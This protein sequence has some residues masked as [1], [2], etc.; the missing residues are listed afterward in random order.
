V[1]FALNAILQRPISLIRLCEFFSD[2]KGISGMCLICNN[3][4]LFVL[5]VAN[6]KMPS[7]RG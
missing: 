7:I 1:P 3:G 2:R 6:R 5:M 4:K